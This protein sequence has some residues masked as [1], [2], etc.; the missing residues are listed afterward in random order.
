MLL[1]ATVLVLLVLAAIAVDLALAQLGQRELANVSVAAANDAATL[2]L[3]EAAF[4]RGG[5]VVLD[6]DRVARAVEDVVRSGL[7]G[8]RHQAVVVES[9]LLPPSAPGCA[10]TVVVRVEAE[11]ELLFAPAI[12][13]AADRARVRAVA[14][15]RPRTGPS[16]CE[17]T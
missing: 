15:S 13:G 11:V 3:S 10:W 8:R 16:D 12:P 7:E 1:P 2:G 17:T 14:S 5:D 4:Y 6:A 9:A